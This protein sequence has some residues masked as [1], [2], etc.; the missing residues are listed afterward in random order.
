MIIKLYYNT[1]LQ[2]SDVSIRQLAHSA[3]KI[4]TCVLKTTNMTRSQS[5]AKTHTFKQHQ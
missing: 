2:E 1:R 4:S 5:F 3:S